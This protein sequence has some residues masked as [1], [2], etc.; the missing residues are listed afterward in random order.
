MTLELNFNLIFCFK[1][2]STI[3]LKLML[4]ILILGWFCLVVIS[5]LF[6]IM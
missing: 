5:L 4:H 6:F 3:P 1:E 2:V